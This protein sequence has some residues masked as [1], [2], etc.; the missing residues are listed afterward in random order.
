LRRA[1]DLSDSLLC[2]FTGHFNNTNR[3]K[4]ISGETRSGKTTYLKKLLNE[5]K[6]ENPDLK[7]GGIIAH[8]IDEDGK[9][10]G[11]EIED[12]STGE[13]MLLSNNIIETGNTRVGRFYFKQKGMEFGR[14][15][16]VNAIEKSDLLIIDEIGHFEL[17]GKGWFDMIEMAM[18]QEDLDMIWVVR[19]SLLGD[20]LKLWSH[21]NVEVIE[22]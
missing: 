11:F 2:S 13:R 14:N 19:K 15:V 16:L 10:L 5:L 17:K 3:I 18:I 12:I 4:I 22:I 7:I 6:S 20:V 9:R 21:S 8:G 1:I